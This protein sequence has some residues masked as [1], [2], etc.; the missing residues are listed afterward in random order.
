MFARP[1]WLYFTFAALGAVIG[2]YAYYWRRRYP[3]EVS[4][5]EEQARRRRWM[6]TPRKRAAVRRR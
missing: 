1:L 4:A 2:Y 6:P 5:Y 3:S